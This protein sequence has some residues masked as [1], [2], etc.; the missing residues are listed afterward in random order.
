MNNTQQGIL[1]ESN[2]TSRYLSFSIS[3]VSHISSCLEELISTIETDSTVVGV[4]LSL[5]SVLGVEIPGL[6]TLKA[7]SINGIDVV[8]T[9]SALWCWLRGTDSGELFHRSLK[10]ESILSPA[11]ILNDVVDAFQ[12]DEN[13]DLS[14]YID[15]TEN[16]T[17]E[18]A[19]KVAV[20]ADAGEGLDGGSYVAVQQWIHD[21][22]VLDDMSISHKDDA[23]GRHIADNEEF[24]S[25]PDSAHVKRSAQE[26][27]TPEAFMLRRSMPWIDG[28][29][30][31]LEFVAFAQ[32]FD[33]FE[34]ILSRMVGA[35]DSVID[36]IFSFTKPI[37]G[38]YYWCPPVKNGK[39][40]LSA[41]GL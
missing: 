2:I 9:P 31:G 19:N 26:S 35:D 38:A 30:G 17:G 16:P 28:M 27:F 4:G 20:V 14:G 22:D 13:R 8:S 5:A 29:S 40:D 12:Y 15:G 39:L 7:Q 32:S 34:A 25:A 6:K 1:E 24:D 41:L 37:N 11:F 33:A 3:S 21:F 23:I 10:I 18:D 36:G